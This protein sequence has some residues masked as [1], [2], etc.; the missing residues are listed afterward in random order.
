MNPT[1]EDTEK[2]RVIKS[3]GGHRPFRQYTTVKELEKPVLRRLC[4][5]DVTAEGSDE[6]IYQQFKQV[7]MQIQ[8]KAVMPYL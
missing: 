2:E 6:E 4:C 5:D 7:A 8:R 3:Y 1:R